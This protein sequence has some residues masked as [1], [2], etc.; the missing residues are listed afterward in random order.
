MNAEQARN[1]TSELAQHPKSHNG[2][3]VDQLRG[4]VWRVIASRVPEQG[5]AAVAEDESGAPVVVGVS[6]GR[7]VR[8]R[9]VGDSEDNFHIESELFRVDTPG[10]TSSVAE[11]LTSAPNDEGVFF[12]REWL[13]V[14]GDGRSV[15][16]AVTSGSANEAFEQALADVAGWPSS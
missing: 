10:V 5:M 8:L 14:L 7:V 4:V 6:R 12:R 15:K 3:L 11:V 2:R 1:L 16:F 9:A 13:Y